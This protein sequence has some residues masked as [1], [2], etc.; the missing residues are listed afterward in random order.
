MTTPTAKDATQKM[1]TLSQCITHAQN[2]GY[3]ENFKVSSQGLTTEDGN[4]VFSHE[5]VHIR[6]FYRFEG[7]SD[8]GDSS[9]LYLIETCNKIRGILIDAYDVYADAKISGFIKQVEDIQK[10]PP[11]QLSWIKSL[12]QK[13][14]DK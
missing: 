11:H 12:T 14:F 9:I 7:Y 5:S 6:N 1:E 10:R 4:S 8:P 3:K 2:E 13:I